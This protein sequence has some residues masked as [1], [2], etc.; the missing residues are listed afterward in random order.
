MENYLN[1]L[2]DERNRIA[3]EL[4]DSVSANLSALVLKMKNENL[5]ETNPLY[6]QE[7]KKIQEDVRKTSHDLHPITLN[8]NSLI[9]TIE[10]EIARLENYFEDITFN[11]SYTNELE[12]N[13]LNQQ[14]K[15]IFYFTCCELIQNVLKHALPTE[16]K[17]ELV[18][19]NK[20][21][22]LIVSDDGIGYQAEQISKGLGLTTIEKRAVLL[23]GSFSIEKKEKGMVHRFELPI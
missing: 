20:S 2:L 12:I 1:G 10:L 23:N 18:I 14:L 15:E 16:V 22:S 5:Q 19:K 17:I 8:N 21:I 4:H 11:F 9:A 13:L 7:L 6:F 3:E